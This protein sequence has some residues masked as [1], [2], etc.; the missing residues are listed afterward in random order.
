MTTVL[1]LT[2]SLR[3]S[4]VEG[5]LRWAVLAVLMSGLT[6]S[7]QDRP[8][9]WL[10]A[11]AMPPGAIG[12]L[13]LERGGPLSGYFQP[14]QIRVP[15]GARIALASEG[16]FS[17]IASGEALVGMQIGL[18][19]RLEISNIPNGE[20]VDI[21]PTV[22][23]IDRLHPPPGL[24]LRFPV[25]IELTRDELD[26]AARGAFVTRVVYVEDPQQALPIA[27]KAND[28]QPW[29]EA[30]AGEDPL[31]AADKNGRPIAI[32]RIGSRRPDAAQP[33]FG[34]PVPPYVVLDPNQGCQRP[35]C[36]PAQKT[37]TP[38]AAPA[39]AGR[40]RTVR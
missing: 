3:R 22:E 12:S 14:V 11:G 21:Y 20:G 7:A 36:P 9:H 34:A 2:R 24:A 40:Q 4:R 23:L 28:E 25:P 31:V 27:R 30:P 13:R 37:T 29:V 6:A 5:I 35:G 16:G 17:Q 1:V 10:H 15:Q 8:V 19:Y 32:V 26:L 38:A 33:G 39:A 18:V